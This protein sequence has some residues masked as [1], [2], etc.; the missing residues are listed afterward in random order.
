VPLLEA[1]QVML[2]GWGR[3]QA[4]EFERAAVGERNLA[5]VAVDRVAADP[6]A[7]ALEARRRVRPDYTDAGAGTVERF[8]RAIATSLGASLSSA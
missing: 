5:V 4:T 3:E 1:D 8:A 7:A 6:E 2:V